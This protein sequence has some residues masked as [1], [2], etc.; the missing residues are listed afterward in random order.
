MDIIQAYGHCGRFEIHTHPFRMDWLTKD[1]RGRLVD[2]LINGFPLEVYTLKDIR[3]D[4][5]YE[6]P[7]TKTERILRQTAKIFKHFYDRKYQGVWTLK[8]IA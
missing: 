5:P 3:D 2:Q 4:D 6:N 7:H 8:G 1:Q